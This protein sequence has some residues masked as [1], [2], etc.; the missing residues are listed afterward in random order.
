MLEEIK[1]RGGD[2]ATLNVT[3]RP[4]QESAR[5]LYTKLGF[6]EIGKEE[7]AGDFILVMRKDLNAE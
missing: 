2:F 1:K 7:D 6:V 3:E 4:E 5:K